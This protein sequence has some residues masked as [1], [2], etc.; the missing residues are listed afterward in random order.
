ML[1]VPGGPRKT[2]VECQQPR[3]AGSPVMLV[4]LWGW[5]PSTAGESSDAVSSLFGNPAVLATLR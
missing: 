4:V 3:G 2:Q 5:Q 1:L